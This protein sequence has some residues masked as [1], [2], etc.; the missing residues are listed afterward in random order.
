MGPAIRRGAFTN[1]K[2]MTWR[3][4]HDLSADA[5]FE[6]CIEAAI[7]H[8]LE[9]AAGDYAQKIVSSSDPTRKALEKIIDNIPEDPVTKRLDLYKAEKTF[10][11]ANQCL[12]A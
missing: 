2:S 7:T 6:E 3:R 12:W 11:T 1:L 4:K 8:H 10:S 5:S 9:P